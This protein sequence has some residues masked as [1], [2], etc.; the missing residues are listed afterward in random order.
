MKAQG[1]WPRLAVLCLLVLPAA[2]SAFAQAGDYPQKTVTIISD[3]GAGA[4]VDVATRVIAAG[5]DKIWGQTVAVVNHPGANGSV[6]ARAASEAAGDGYTLY[7]PASSTFIALPTVA[8]NLPIKLP[9]DF[10]PIGFLADQPLFLAVDPASGITS[11][12]QLI[13][14]AKKAPATISTAVSGVGRMTHLTSVL[15]QQ[16]AGIKL[17]TVP[18]T[19]GPSAALADVTSGR[20]TMII[21]GYSG[22]IG[23]VNAGQ[24]KL[25][26]T[27]A[28]QRLAEFPDLPTVAETIPGLSASGWI[29]MAAPIGTPAPVI[30]KVG[31]DLT[32]VVSDPDIKKRLAVTGNYTHA[33]TPD[34]TQAFVAKEQETWLPVVQ[35][36]STQ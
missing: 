17:I 27:A 21:E 28:S 35:S 18:Y 7:T 1:N 15:I 30:A 14:R 5:L 20:V 6:A 26:A 19:G 29:A 34:E 16:R 2:S 36:I 25:I 22:I 9:R 12:R 11:L 3:A 24:V 4:S 23:A 8:P 13:D 31:A 33:M 32:K 10:L